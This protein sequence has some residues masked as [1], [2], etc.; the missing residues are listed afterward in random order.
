[1]KHKKLS[2]ALLKKLKG[3]LN[4]CYE[5]FC[6]GGTCGQEKSTDCSNNANRTLNI[7]NP[8]GSGTVKPTK[9]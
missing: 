9:K 7:G 5:T 2:K 4:I 1:M 8:G 3:G 6:V